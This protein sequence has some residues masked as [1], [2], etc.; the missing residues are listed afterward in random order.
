MEVS[1]SLWRVR[2]RNGSLL[3]ISVDQDRELVVHL[4]IRGPSRSE[5][6]EHRSLYSRPRPSGVGHHLLGQ[7]QWTKSSLLLQEDLTKFLAVRRT[8]CPPGSSPE[9]SIVA[10]FVLVAPAADGVEVLQAEAER[11]ELR[12]ADGAVR[13]RPVLL[14][15]LPE[16][17]GQLRPLV[18]QLEVRHV[19]RGRRRGRPRGVCSR[20]HFPRLTGEVRVGFEVMVRMLAIVRTPPRRPSLNVDLAILLVDPGPSELKLER[21]AIEPWRAWPLTTV[22]F[23]VD[24]FEDAP[25]FLHDRGE[26]HLR[27]FL[28]G[29]PERLGRRSGNLASC[30]V[31]SFRRFRSWSHWPAKFS[32]NWFDFLLLRIRRLACSTRTFSGPEASSR[33]ARSSSSRS[34]MLAPEEVREPGGELEVADRE[35]QVGFEASERPRRS[36]LDLEQEMRR[37]QDR[38]ERELNPL[39]ELRPPSFWTISASLTRRSTSSGGRGPAIPSIGEVFEDRPAILRGRS[40][41]ASWRRSSTCLCDLRE[42]LD[43]GLDRPLDLDPLR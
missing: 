40:A 24:E 1:P 27:L 2:L 3:T 26:V 34:G 21:D 22:Q 9:G 14:H 13:I 43:L 20:T 15:L 42:V 37:D 19:R 6:T 18:F 29:R 17:A 36:Y 28:H 11:V 39:F 38:L 33:F 30:R 8:S 25:V 5:S 16:G 12:V 35:G 32:T 4:W 41:P 10:S 23:G 31:G 7:R